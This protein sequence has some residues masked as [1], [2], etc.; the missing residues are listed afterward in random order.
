[1]GI[2]HWELSIGQIVC[3]LIRDR[4]CEKLYYGSG[5]GPKSG[6]GMRCFVAASYAEAI[7]KSVGTEKGRPQNMTPTGSFAGTGPT[8]RV[9]PRAAVSRTRSNTRVVKPAGTDSVGMPCC[10]SSPQTEFVLPSN[11]GSI[12]VPRIYAGMFPAVETRASRFCWAMHCIT[13]CW[14]A[15]LS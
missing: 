12:G 11:G 1:M 4:I 13:T 9:P 10:P 8:K 5:T 15:N 14:Y 7:R 2:E 6:G 3:F